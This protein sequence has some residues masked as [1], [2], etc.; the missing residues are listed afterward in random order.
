MAWRNHIVSL[1]TRERP[2]PGRHLTTAS[3]RRL[4]GPR[5]RSRSSAG[6]RQALKVDQVHG[7]VDDVH[8]HG[9][10]EA[11]AARSAATLF[12][13]AIIAATSNANAPDS[14]A[15]VRL[16]ARQ[17][18][19]HVPDNLQGCLLLLLQTICALSP[20]VWRRR[21][22]AGRED[23]LR[24][25]LK[26]GRQW[27]A[28]PRNPVRARASAAGWASSTRPGRASDAGSGS[29]TGSPRRLPQADR[30]GVRGLERIA[31]QR[32]GGAQPGESPLIISRR[33]ISQPPS[34]IRYAE[35]RDTHSP[36]ARPHREPPTE[37]VASRPTP[38]PALVNWRDW[39]PP[40]DTG[41]LRP[42]GGASRRNDRSASRDSRL[43]RSGSRDTS[44]IETLHPRELKQGDTR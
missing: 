3:T 31:C 19:V 23:L 43:W 5:E 35:V 41:P 2:T 17:C 37:D 28:P 16:S 39:P 34:P 1:P 40:V 18:I 11:S 27:R 4:Q 6:F 26:V 10:V 25:R 29:T 8:R 30:A 15:R 13:F 33:T 7:V 22:T 20:F 21:R 24:S 9:T 36:P 32:P 44:S 14:S 38:Q 42:R 12:E